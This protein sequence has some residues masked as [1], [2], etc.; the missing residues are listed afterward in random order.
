MRDVLFE[1]SLLGGVDDGI[2]T[3]NVSNTNG[4]GVTGLGESF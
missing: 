4:W 2:Q 3:G 1:A